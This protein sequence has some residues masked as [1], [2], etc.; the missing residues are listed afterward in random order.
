[1][2][3]SEPATPA[4]LAARYQLTDLTIEEPEIET[5]IRH[6]YEGGL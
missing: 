3:S 4:D 2:S 6:I 1:M 5:I